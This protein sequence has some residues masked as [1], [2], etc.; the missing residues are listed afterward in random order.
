MY[1]TRRLLTFLLACV[2]PGVA[3]QQQ[4]ALPDDAA[5]AVVQAAERSVDSTAGRRYAAPVAQSRSRDAL[6]RQAEVQRLRGQLALADSAYQRLLGQD[7][8]LTDG[9]ARYGAM[10]RSQVAIARGA[11]RDAGLWARRARESAQRAGDPLTEADASLPL[12]YVLD[13]TISTE[14]AE[15]L[16]LK[17]AEVLPA[18]AD[19]QWARLHCARLGPPVQAGELDERAE[20]LAGITRARRAG[21]KRTEAKCFIDYAQ[22]WYGRRTDSTLAACDHAIDLL[23]TLDDRTG[24]LAEA[25]YFRGTAQVGS[26]DYGSA[27][28]S[29][30]NALDAAA[31]SS[32]DVRTG[33][34]LLQL[35]SLSLR[36]RSLNEGLRF[37]ARA[38][39]VVVAQGN[40]R[41]RATLWSI[42]GD[43]ARA[44][45][46]TAAA[47]LAYRA[48]L[49]AAAPFGGYGR[50]A[51]YRG[52][53][54]LARDAGDWAGA[55][56]SL[57]S[58]RSAAGTQGL[59]GWARR[60][61]Y[62]AAVLALERG[63]PEGAERAFRKFIAGLSPEDRTTAFAARMRL[64]E[65]AARRGDVV[66]GGAEA[67]AAMDDLAAWRATLGDADLRL[68]TFELGELD[69]SPSLGLAVVVAA[70]TK[71]GMA[72]EALDLAERRRARELLDQL[73][74][75]EAWAGGSGVPGTRVPSAVLEAQAIR[76]A[77]PTGTALLEIVIGSSREPATALLVTRTGI[78]GMSL[79]EVSKVDA[80][81]RRFSA[82]L[83]AGDS[84]RRIDPGLTHDLVGTALE[85]LPPDVTR[86][87][88][89]PDGSLHGVPFEALRRGDALLGDAIQVI[90]APSAS[91]ALR[92]DARPPSA[93][94]RGIL[95]LGN[96]TVPTHGASEATRLLAT[97]AQRA[98]GLA[99]LPAAGDEVRAAVRR[100]PS[101]MA[102]VGADASE[103][104]FRNA[105]LKTYRV[106]HL[107]AHA[108]VSEDEE[109]GAAVVLAPG[110][111]Q[112]GFLTTTDLASLAL[113]AELVLLSGCRTAGGVV[114]GGEGVQG[115][116]ATILSAGARAVLATRW[117]VPDA[118]AARFVDRFYEE[119]TRDGDAAA[120]LQ[121]SRLAAERSGMTPLVWTAFVLTGSVRPRVRL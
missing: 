113:D 44:S 92:L 80:A 11:L 46:D 110:G 39:S 28:Q 4:R 104:W 1:T 56:A 12:A 117:R 72:A 115:L 91:V 101:S 120:A 71:D 52:L 107:A 74:R 75:A 85:N 65:L 25:W 118:A 2:A 43:L 95:A 19:A 3:A 60:L 8:I 26:R 73:V 20:A 78:V 97:A 54:A 6:L 36:F 53:A 102:R 66:R 59:G 94:T 100:S 67:R 13:R 22:A 42:Q 98:G 64:A 33:A 16:Y 84:P 77:L 51:P 61:D 70:L 48:A 106:I 23:R 29:L 50:V 82:L 40:L 81:A 55:D 96:P 93:A 27:R 9:I 112:D 24:L 38:E 30:L 47:R 7:S 34:I 15:S 89:I 58:A 88:V 90:V 86:L 37:A 103:A 18:S 21:D 5:R 99:P 62:D 14:A 105:P 45:G 76:E 10:G 79:P 83:S 87:V 57:T 32:Y 17:T 31:E 35:A 109:V 41:T 63:D 49:E 111:G 114:V 119:L 108:I 121:R 68:R 116:T 69:L